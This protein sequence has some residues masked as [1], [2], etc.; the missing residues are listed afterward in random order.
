MINKMKICKISIKKLKRASIYYV[1]A[2]KIDK[3]DKF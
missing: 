3:N 2:K 1:K